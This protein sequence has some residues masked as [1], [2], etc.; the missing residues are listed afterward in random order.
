MSPS[1]KKLRL[2]SRSSS[3]ACSFF[4]TISDATKSY[5][6][7]LLTARIRIV[8]DGM[9]ARYAT[10]L[11]KN[12]FA[13]FCVD[14]RVYHNCCNI[15]EANLSGIPQLRKFC[16]EISAK[17]QFRAAY[18]YIG[19]ELPTLLSSIRL[20]IEATRSPGKQDLAQM[21]SAESLSSVRFPNDYIY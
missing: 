16:Y 9:K 10:D 13:V 8:E 11:E 12:K 17:A 4:Q 3:F 2:N 7:L 21:V 6:T 5:Q 20:W 1:T 15:E 18:Q 14:N 19:T